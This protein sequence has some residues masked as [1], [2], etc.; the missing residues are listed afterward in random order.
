[1]ACLSISGELMPG[2]MADTTWSVRMPEKLKEKINQLIEETGLT[3]KDFVADMVQVYELNKVREMSR[4]TESDIRELQRLTRRINAIFVNVIERMKTQHEF[5]QKEA[6]KKLQEKDANIQEQ[7]NQINQLKQKIQFLE[8]SIMAMEEAKNEADKKLEEQQEANSL[9]KSLVREYEAKNNALQE[10]INGLYVCKEENEEL[11]NELNKLRE[12]NR[13]Y[14]ERLDQL[15]REKAAEIEML[16][17]EKGR[18][19]SIVRSEYEK[20]INVLLEQKLEEYLKEY[21]V[22]G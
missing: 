7:R 17:L 19:V 5:F 1:M 21:A 3:N 13:M 8:Q 20:R 14:T 16:K 9:L 6:D 4:E 10:E 15:E 22:K 18:A 12:E 11:K 2:E